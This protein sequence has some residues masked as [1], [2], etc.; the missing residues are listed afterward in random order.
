M[1][2]RQ[3]VLL[4]EDEVLIAMCLEMELEQSGHTIC[5][6]VAT[7]EEAIM[8]ATEKQPDVILMDI[9][10]AGTINGIE[11]ARQIV[12]EQQIPIIFMSGY[13]DATL[14]DRAMQLHPV[15]YLIKPVQFSD[16][17]AALNIACQ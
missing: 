15:A 1:K 17:Q 5:Y 11:A 3:R 9:R 2:Q 8:V 14:K 16:I 12:A 7:G 6:R 10:L 13:E 4:V